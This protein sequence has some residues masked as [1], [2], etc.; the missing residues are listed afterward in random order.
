MEP[1]PEIVA[2][3]P[4]RCHTH[5]VGNAHE[6][7]NADDTIV[8]GPARPLGAPAPLGPADTP[9]GVRTARHGLTS[10]RVV[11]SALLVGWVVW[12]IA[13]WVVQP[14]LVPHNVLAEELSQGYVRSYR[15][16]TVDENDARGP[17]SP[18]RLDIS[19]AADALDGEGDGIA[20]GDQLTVAYWVDAP[21]A[22]LRVL[23]PDGLSPDTPAAV[24]A[25]FTAAGVPEAEAADLQVRPPAQ[26][27]GN[28]GTLLLL[29]STLAVILGPRPRRGTRWFWFWVVGGPLSV[30]VPIYAVAELLRPR[31]EPAGTVHPPGVA[32]RWRGL[33]GFVASILL[34]LV[35]TVV[36]LALDAVSPIW[37]PRG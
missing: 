19:P 25:R 6:P 7:A 23:D 14:R 36:I 18:Y 1:S 32:G 4:V 37:F 34:F 35:G 24:V 3:R 10:R 26:R 12:L 15:V 11:G 22:S 17:W 5:R 2:S 20:D 27:V 9:P 13:V 21:V 8:V 29:V 16:V 31:D 30:G 28:A 33:T